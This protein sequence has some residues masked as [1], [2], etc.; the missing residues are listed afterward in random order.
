MDGGIN[1][2]LDSGVIA[3]AAGQTCPVVGIFVSVRLHSLSLTERESD[4][5]AQHS[6]YPKRDE[7]VRNCHCDLPKEAASLG[8]LFHS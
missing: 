5:G 1:E 6:K 7:P 2:I 3:T 4:K 8:G